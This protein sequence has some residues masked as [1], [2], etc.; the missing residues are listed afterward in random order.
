VKLVSLAVLI[1]VV[2][3]TFKKGRAQAAQSPARRR[4]IVWRAAVII[5]LGL[6]IALLLPQRVPMNVESPAGVVIYLLCWLIGG[7]LALQGVISLL[8]ALLARPKVQG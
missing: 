2:L 8:A 6:A 3:W 1:A 5:P 4:F 7:L